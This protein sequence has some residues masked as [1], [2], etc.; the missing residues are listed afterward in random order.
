[1]IFPIWHFD[2]YSQAPMDLQTRAEI[3]AA[4]EVVQESGVGGAPVVHATAIQILGT[5]EDFHNLDKSISKET[6]P[7]TGLLMHLV[8]PT[9]NGFEILDVWDQP[10][11]AEAFFKERLDP[12]LQERGLAFTRTAESEIWSI[13]RT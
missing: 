9:E 12:L 11:D 10:R 13:A 1:M 4:E 2:D 3:A 7:P 5:K 8:R 6:I